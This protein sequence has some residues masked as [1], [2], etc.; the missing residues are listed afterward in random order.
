M[1]SSFNT[2][3]QAAREREA[4]RRRGFMAPAPESIGAQLRRGNPVMV[5]DRRTGRVRLVTTIED[6]LAAT[7]QNR[8]IGT[9]R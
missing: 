7:E 3:R 8:Q 5:A 9:N 4:R 1:T 6:Y 2:T